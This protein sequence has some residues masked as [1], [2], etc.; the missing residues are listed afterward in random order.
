MRNIGDS[1]VA[2]VRNI[3]IKSHFFDKYNEYFMEK[4]TFKKIVNK[5][6]VNYL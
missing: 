2:S 4:L 6:F 1:W 3:V 5:L